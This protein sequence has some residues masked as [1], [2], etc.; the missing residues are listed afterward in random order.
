[1]NGI[2][3]AIYT[4]QKKHPEITGIFVSDNCPA[5]E[6][7]ICNNNSDCQGL[8]DL[9]V[10]TSEKGML[11]KLPIDPM[12]GENSSGLG[13]HV[14]KNEKGRITICAPHTESGYILSIT[15]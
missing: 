13:F 14:V 15:R 9:S 1:M 4:Y 3:D 5:V 6:N 12:L 2:L 10:L 11:N 8:I 7:E